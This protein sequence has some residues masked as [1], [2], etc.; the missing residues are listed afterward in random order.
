MSFAFYYPLSFKFKFIHDCMQN[1][2]LQNHKYKY[3][4][5]V[6]NKI[7]NRFS[8]RYFSYNSVSPEVLN[9]IKKAS[10]ECLFKLRIENK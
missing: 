7:T 9:F 5:C 6:Y 4:E 1:S 3:C 10:K 8:Y 2:N